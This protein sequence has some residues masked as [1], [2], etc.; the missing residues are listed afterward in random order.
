[1]SALSF[2]QERGRGE[3]GKEKKHKKEETKKQIE[4]GEGWDIEVGCENEFAPAA[5]PKAVS[6][7][8]FFFFAT[9]TL[10][11]VCANLGRA[12]IEFDKR[13]IDS[14]ASDAGVIRLMRWR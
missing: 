3:G 12:E 10:V 1:M 4:G 14:Q 8:F 6:P 7:F 13:E 2:D 5:I 9:S 11:P